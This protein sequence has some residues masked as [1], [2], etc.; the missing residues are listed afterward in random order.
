[1][2]VA[3]NVIRKVGGFISTASLDNYCALNSVVCTTSARHLVSDDLADYDNAYYPVTG[4][5]SVGGVQ[6]WSVKRNTLLGH[7]T[8]GGKAAPGIVRKSNCLLSDVRSKFRV[9]QQYQS[10]RHPG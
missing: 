10:Q 6:D 2:L 1:M 3:N 7:N 4:G 8:A 5:L 9:E